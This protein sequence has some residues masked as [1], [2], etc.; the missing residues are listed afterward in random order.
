MESGRTK[1]PIKVPAGLWKAMMGTAGRT[2]KD[3][4]LLGTVWVAGNPYSHAVPALV[5][6]TDVSRIEARPVVPVFGIAREP[7]AATTY[8][9]GH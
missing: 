1:V 4:S 7:V 8:S 5:S 9:S 6:N 2:V 3:I